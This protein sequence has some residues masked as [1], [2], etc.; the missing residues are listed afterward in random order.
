M[1]KTEKAFQRSWL[2]FRRKNLDRSHQ[3]LSGFHMLVEENSRWRL[4]KTKNL[5]RKN[6]K[7]DGFKGSISWI[8]LESQ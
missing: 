3:R 2:L 7:I 4:T 8:F 1:G 5:N 6:W